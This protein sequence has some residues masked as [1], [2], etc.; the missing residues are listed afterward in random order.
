MSRRAASTATREAAGGAADAALPAYGRDWAFFLDIDGTL[1]E[2]AETPDA[3]QTDPADY[4]LLE[5]VH[6]AAGGALALV[7]GRTLAMI[8][9]LFAP[10]KLPAAGQHG[11]E[12][13]DGEGRRRRHRFDAAR[14]RPLATLLEQFARKHPGLVFEDKGASVALHYRLAPELRDIAHGQA[15]AAAAMLPGEVE[16]QP[17]KMVWEVKPVGAHK[18]MAIE[19]FM[20]ELP[21]RDRLP[22]YLGDDVTDEDGFRVV[23]RIGGHSIKVGAGE[24]SARFRL[25][26][27]AAARA[28]LD[29]WASTYR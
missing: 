15:L 25:P 2:I 13:R 9:D 27:P 29:G 6:A 8:D 28:W 10:L 11:F 26:D 20:R 14:L 23:N 22:V 18:G 21:F 5:R 3:V 1:L 16:V 7:S 4:R 24:T 17:G 19:E 12:R